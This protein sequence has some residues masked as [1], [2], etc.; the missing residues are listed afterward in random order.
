VTID[1]LYLVAKRAL[2]PRRL[3]VS[4]KADGVGAALTSA[5]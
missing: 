4:T 5:A 1:E 3:W 2:A